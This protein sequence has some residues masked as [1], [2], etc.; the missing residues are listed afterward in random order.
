MNGIPK[1]LIAAD[2]HPDKQLPEKLPEAGFELTAFWHESYCSIHSSTENS[3]GGDL[4]TYLCKI[5][6]HTYQVAL[7]GIP[8]ELI[9]TDQ[10]GETSNNGDWPKSGR[11][12]REKKVSTIR[13]VQVILLGSYK[14]MKMIENIAFHCIGGIG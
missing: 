8:K 14:Q 7:N 4:I 2:F 1:E 10:Y 9:A 13:F 5:Q 12:E 6:T 11:R 3:Q